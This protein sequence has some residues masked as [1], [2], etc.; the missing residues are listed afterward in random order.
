M[1]RHRRD[2]QGR[3]F[4]VVASEVRALAQRSATAAAEIKTLIQGS[5]R[6]V[7]RGGAMVGEAGRTMDD[8]VASVARIAGYMGDISHASEEQSAGIA[9]VNQAIGAIDAATQ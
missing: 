4:A 9:Q 1:P 8:I 5:V 7:E 6:Q 2:E 3:G